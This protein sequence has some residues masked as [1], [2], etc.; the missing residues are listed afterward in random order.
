MRTLD[1]Y[2]KNIW[3]YSQAM[4]QVGLAKEQSAT[5]LNNAHAGLY[6]AQANI[7]NAKMTTPKPKYSEGTLNTFAKQNSDWIN[8]NREEHRRL[9]Q[10][11]DAY[12]NI[13]KYIQAEVDDP[14]GRAGSSTL[15]KIQRG[16]NK[17][18]TESEKNQIL[19]QYETQ[20]LMQGLKDIFKG[21]TSD[22][23]IALFIEGL[24]SLDK[25]P[26]A[27]I[28]ISKQ[29]ADDIRKRLK[30]DEVTQEVLEDEF[31][32][33][34]PYNSLAVQRRVKEKLPPEKEVKTVSMTAPDGTTREVPADKVE[35]WKSKGA[36]VINEQK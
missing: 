34:E 31:G 9:K 24:P 7:E 5:N 21:A 12:T 2:S 4:Q 20:P 29:R 17:A 36:K 33:S 8:N 15:S 26:Q 19:I 28:Q 10:E 3:E 1:P 27:S 30:E 18:N 14:T 23:D 16:L 32:Y 13:A 6:N 35:Y 25:N 22:R 11:A